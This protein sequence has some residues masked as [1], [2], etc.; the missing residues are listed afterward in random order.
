MTKVI[1]NTET[2]EDE[3][4]YTEDE[5][6]ERETAAKAAAIEEY[7]TQNPDKTGEITKLQS[8]LEA[9]TKD[10][11]KYKNK[12]MNFGNLRQIKEDLETKVNDLTKEIDSKVTAGIQQHSVEQ[13]IKMRAGGD[14]E[15]E[16]KIKFEFEKT[17]SGVQPKTP[18]ELNKKI[19]DACMLATGAT[20]K[21]DISGGVLGSGGATMPRVKKENAGNLKPEVV[22]LGKRRFGLSEEDIKKHDTQNFSNTP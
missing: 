15:L 7:K 9:A 20:S 13:S 3:T 17:L 5:I 8:D 12:D 10:L 1:K 11:E 18:E 22:D 16:K 21:V 2:G 6:A 14:A 19:Q 4:V